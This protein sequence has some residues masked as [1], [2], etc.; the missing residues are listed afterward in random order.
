MTLEGRVALITGA[1]Q[2]IG[3]AIAV[4]LAAAG[5]SVA[6]AARNQD[7]LNESSSR[8]HLQ[9]EKRPRFNSTLPTKSKSS[10]YSRL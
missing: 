4:R 6:L 3:Q 10:L 2:G 8:S 9:A 1:S 7:K 5:A